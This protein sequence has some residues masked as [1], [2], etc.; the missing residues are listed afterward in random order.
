MRKRVPTVARYSADAEGLTL[1]G[2]E[3]PV[4]TGGEDEGSTSR[5]VVSSGESRG[6]W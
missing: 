5:E 3:L 2:K 6:R 1:D 4:A